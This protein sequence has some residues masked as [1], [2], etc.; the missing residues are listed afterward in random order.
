MNEDLQ[1][2]QE[3]I[4]LEYGSPWVPTLGSSIVGASRDLKSGTKPVNGMRIPPKGDSSGWFIW[5][6]TTLSDAP[7]FFA[8]VHA[9]HVVDWCPDIV[10][11]LGLAPGWRFLWDGDYLDVWYDPELLKPPADA[12]V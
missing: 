10:R 11:L 5:A 3:L 2:S 12:D 6:G 7:D 1:V 8:P 4:C 9:G